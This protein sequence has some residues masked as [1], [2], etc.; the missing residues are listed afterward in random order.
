MPKL[1]IKKFTKTAFSYK[2]NNPKKK[3]K[4]QNVD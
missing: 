1:E 4:N 3:K 2:K